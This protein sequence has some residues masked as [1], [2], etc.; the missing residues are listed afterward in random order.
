M[1]AADKSSLARIALKYSSIEAFAKAARTTFNKGR[2]TL[3]SKKSF[4]EGQRI[5]LAIKLPG[6]NV[7]IISEVIQKVSNGDE[8]AP[9]TYGIRWL[10]FTEKKLTKV[11]EG[12]GGAAAPDRAPRQKPEPEAAPPPAPSPPRREQAPA[13]AEPPAPPPPPTPS[14]PKTEAEADT[15]LDVRQVTETDKKAAVAPDDLEPTPAPPPDDEGVTPAPPPEDEEPGLAPD[16]LEPTPAPPPDDEGVTPAPP[17]EDEEP[18]LAPDDLEPTPAPPPEDEGEDID[19]MLSGLVEEPEAP[20]PPP[21][22]DKIHMP[23][24]PEDDE[25][26]GSL[27]FMDQLEE[28]EPAAPAEPE[29]AE[30]APPSEPAEPEPAAPTEDAESADMIEPIE[31]E[32][33]EGPAEEPLPAETSETSAEESSGAPEPEPA[34]KEAEP[35]PAAARPLSGEELSALGVFL[36]KLMRYLARPETIEGQEGV[37][38]MKSLYDDF[39]EIMRDREEIGIF[40]RNAGA[41]REYMLFGHMPRPVNLKASMP[42]AEFDEL[43]VKLVEVFEKKLLIGI[44]FRRYLTEEAFRSFVQLLGEYDPVVETP[45]ELA[46]NLLQDGVFHATPVH[47]ADRVSSSAEL[48]FRVDSTLSRLRG[49]IVRLRLSAEAIMEDPVALLTL[50]VEDALKALRSGDLRARALLHAN[51]VVEGQD[52]VSERDLLQEII[53]ATPIEMLVDS[54]RFL[55][56]RYERLF[57]GLERDRENEELQAELE[58]VR[59]VLRQ[60]TAR[61]TVDDPEAA[62]EVMGG[63]YKKGVFTLDELPPELR[64]QVMLEYF[65]EN[66]RADPD[67]RLADFEALDNKRAY[68]VSATRYMRMTGELVRQGDVELADRIFQTVIGHIRAKDRGFEGR[69]KL[70]R[71]SLAVLAKPAVINGMARTL[72]KV[73]KNQRDRIAAMIF[74]AGPDAAEGLIDLLARAEDRSLRRLLCEILTRM[75]EAVAPAIHERLRAPGTP[76]FLIRNLVMIMGDLKSPAAIE[77]IEWLG[78]HEHPRVREETLAYAAKTM[79]TESKQMMVE[80]LAD[81]NP[82]VKKRA[83][84]I[85]M[86]FPDLDDEAAAKVIAMVEKKTPKDPPPEEEQA[87]ES[88]AD[89]IAKLGP[90][91]LPDGATVEDKL[92]EILE[93]EQAKGLLGRITGAKSTRT[94]R[95]K[96]ALIKALGATGAD[97]SMK[98]LQGFQKEKDPAVKEAARNALGEIERR[99]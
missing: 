31:P 68:K 6:K 72:E 18:G 48:D 41:V 52:L 58:S 62:G 55:A 90:R 99:R 19:G 49:E 24:P 57:E 95:M 3:K 93:P 56:G 71:Q 59:D 8:G 25:F 35:Q 82:D 29:P 64:E 7:E 16:D 54:A 4:E 11:M 21:G 80:A 61:L 23:L 83:L 89:L 94:P 17:P 74:A 12:N 33:E 30:P 45:Q 79:A 87:I 75:G 73:D 51:L 81:V 98:L 91:D 85:L 13:V 2:M 15:S 63:L 34:G 92:I 20:A 77:D 9:N 10:N 38:P 46:G 22:P 47:T 32:I 50:R 60:V 42:V 39:K 76:W 37:D 69:D 36:Q 27:N 43:A 84:R 28:P 65:I 53:L 5:I 86:K 40:V 97:K 96:A 26:D 1:P 70:A 78:A 66:F 14:R 67:T 44:Q 88:A